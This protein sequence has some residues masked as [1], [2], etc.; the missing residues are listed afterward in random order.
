[1]NFTIHVDHEL[2][3]VRYTH[4]GE[5]GVE[6]IGMAWD[7]LLKLDE[8]TQQHYNLLTMRIKS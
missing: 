4:V 5:I 1:M 7:E 8:F 2:R 6:E 3:V